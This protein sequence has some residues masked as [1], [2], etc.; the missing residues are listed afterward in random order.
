MYKQMLN[1]KKSYNLY[2]FFDY[3]NT[4]KNKP[5]ITWTGGKRRLIPEIDKRL[6][7]E[8]KE[9]KIRNFCEPFL[10]G[11]AVFL[12]LIQ[13]YGLEKVL[14]LDI[15]QDLILYY[16]VIKNNPYEFIE[17]IEKYQEIYLGLNKQ[18]KEKFY[19]KIRNEF[20]TVKKNI[21]YLNY[22]KNIDDFIDLS[23]KFH[24]LISTCFNGIISFNSKKEFNQ[25]YDHCKDKKNIFIKKNI[26]TFSKLVQNIDF[27]CA[28][29]EI[30]ENFIDDS[31]FVYFDPPY[32]PASE[33]YK[34]IQ[35][36][37]SFF[38]DNEQIRLANL[39]KRL[40]KKGA[41]LMLSNSDPKNI[42]PNDNFFEDLYKG[43]NINRV[44]IKRLFCANPEK[45]KEVNELIITNY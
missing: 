35:Y 25:S 4:Q 29:F 40:D 24:F 17:R 23:A 33:S 44:K 20:N 1:I 37:G 9:G 26:I 43:Y 18:D 19:Y 16:N 45:R 28:D 21:D 13:N 2:L 36:Y 3:S 10:G 8:L 7:K 27:I 34:K 39:F 31:F 41:L 30:I 12:H 11:G 42:N 22:Q 15:N 6:P 14:L 32:R 38:D 5:I